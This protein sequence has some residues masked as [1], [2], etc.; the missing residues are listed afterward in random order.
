MKKVHILFIGFLF[1]IVGCSSKPSETEISAALRKY[2]NVNICPGLIFKFKQTNSIPKQDDKH[3]KLELDVSYELVGQATGATSKALSI[4]QEMLK[5]IELKQEAELNRYK[6]RGSKCLQCVELDWMTHRISLQ[7]IKAS[8]EMD[9]TEKI[10][11]LYSAG[12]SS[13]T[14]SFQW[15]MIKQILNTDLSSGLII[16]NREIIDMVKSDNG[17]ILDR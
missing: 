3:I 5:S 12:C 10:R 13:N 16:S 15:K 4:Q 6:E 14:Q 17:W 7:N 9:A 2:Y 11:N 8:L 1:L